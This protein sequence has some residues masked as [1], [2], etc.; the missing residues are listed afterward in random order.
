MSNSYAHTDQQDNGGVVTLRK[1]NKTKLIES[2]EFLHRR[3]RTV[4][5]KDRGL[6]A[7]LKQGSKSWVLSSLALQ[8]SVRGV[9]NFKGHVSLKGYRAYQGAWRWLM[10][11][12]LAIPA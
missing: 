8:Q 11:E 10:A 6:W 9:R 7:I 1:K 4:W 12:E 5:L 2:A 3:S